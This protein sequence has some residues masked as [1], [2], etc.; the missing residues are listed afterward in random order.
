MEPEQDE[1]APYMLGLTRDLDGDGKKIW[2]LLRLK[3]VILKRKS[4][5]FIRLKKVVPER[6]GNQD[7]NRMIRI[8]R[9]GQ[10]RALWKY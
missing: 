4:N 5:Q 8:I 9:D 10:K 3:K 1:N 6:K 7:R 2:D